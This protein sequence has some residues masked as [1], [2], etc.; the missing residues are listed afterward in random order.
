L[1][2]PPVA[3]PP[4]VSVGKNSKTLLLRNVLNVKSS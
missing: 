2:N 1:L 4:V 3:S